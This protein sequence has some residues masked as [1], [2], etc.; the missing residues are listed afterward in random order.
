[1]LH[2]AP[3]PPRKLDRQIPRD[4]ETI[5][6]KAI[7]KEPAQRYASAEEMAED[8]RRFLADRPVLA[9]RSSPTEQ[10]WRWCRRNRPGRGH[11]VAFAG[12]VAAVVVLAISNSGSRGP[13]GNWPRPWRRRTAP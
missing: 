3:A 7:A 13:A 2:D 11:A 8:L 6:L 5:V 1:M 9:R 10:A 4:L 12:L